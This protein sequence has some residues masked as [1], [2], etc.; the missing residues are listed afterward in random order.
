MADCRHCLQKYEMVASHSK[1]Q[2][3]HEICR[4]SQNSLIENWWP[5]TLLSLLS[6]I[7]PCLHSSWVEWPEY[8]CSLHCAK[9]CP[10][11]ISTCM[12]VVVSC[13]AVLCFDLCN[14]HLWPSSIPVKSPLSYPISALF[15]IFTCTSAFYSILLEWEEI[16]TVAIENLS[17]RMVFCHSI[18]TANW[19]PCSR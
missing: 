7:P 5:I 17:H 13:F 11:T 3:H 6:H 19:H 16:W 9:S 12:Y 15:V 1:G 2:W 4:K 14:P 8:I 18:W 10:P